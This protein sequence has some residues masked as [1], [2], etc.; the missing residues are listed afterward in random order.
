MPSVFQIRYRGYK[1]ILT[2][3]PSMR[4]KILAKFRDSMR[5]FKGA[6]DHGLYVVDYSKPYA[7][8]YLNDETVLLL[9]AL[10]VSKDILLGK[11]AEYLKFLQTAS[12]GSDGG[13][14]AFKFCTLTNHMDLAETLLIEGLEKVLPQVRTL[15]NQENHKLLNKKS[16]RRCRIMVPKSRLIFGVCDPYD[17]L[18]EGQC[19]VRITHDDDGVARTITGTEVLV[20][21]NPCLHPGDLQKFR[22]VNHPKLSDLV[23]CIVFPTKGRRPSADLMSGGDLDGDKFLVCWDPDLVPKIISEPALYPGAKETVTFRPITHQD[24]LE[25][26]A[27]Y[28]SVSLGRVKNLYLDWARLKGPMSPE[29]QQLNRLFSQCV[30]GNRIKVPA[31]LEDPPKKNQEIDDFILDVLHKASFS[32]IQERLTAQKD[33]DTFPFEVMEVL[34]SNE[35]GAISEFERVKIAHRWLL[36]NGGEFSDFLP[37]F[38]LGLLTDEEKAWTLSLL[39]ISAAGPSLLM[40]GLLQSEL[41]EPPELVNFQLHHPIFHWKPTFNSST[42][43]LET[44]LFSVSRSMELFHK[45]LII[46]R[47][48]ERLTV[49]IYI[50]QKLEKGQECQVG[51]SVRVFAFPR[52]QG[53]NSS[54]YRV[55]PTKVNYRLFCDDNVL[56]LYDGK[57]ANTF[58]FLSEGPQ[59]DS[60]YRQEKGGG[61]RRRQKQ[62]AFEDG[63]NYACRA[64]ISLDK[65]SKD[66]QT[67]VGR[68]NRSGILAAEVYVISNRDVESLRALDLWLQYVDTQEK[69]P[70]FEDEAK[71]FSIPTLG[72]IEWASEPAF[73]EDILQKEN[74]TALNNLENF[75]EI[76]HVMRLLLQHNERLRLRR[77]FDHVLEHVLPGKRNQRK[78]L[79]PFL[80]NILREAPFLIQAFLI[81]NSWEALFSDL[82]EDFADAAPQLLT[83]LVIESGTMHELVL[84]PFKLVLGKLKYLSLQHLSQIVECIALTVRSAELAMDIFLGALE[85]EGS[86]LLV[87]RRPAIETFMRGIFGIALDHIDEALAAKSA[88]KGLLNLTHKDSVS[89]SSIVEAQLRVDAPFARFSKDD[90]V[91]LTAANVPKNFPFGRPFSMDAIVQSAQLGTATFRCLHRPPSYLENCSWH[92]KNCGSFVTSRAMLDAVTEFYTNRECCPIF[93]ELAGLVRETSVFANRDTLDLVSVPRADLNASQNRAIEAAMRSLVCL[94]WGPPGTGKTRTIVA[95]IQEMLLAEPEKRILV[96]APTHNAVDNVLRKYLDEVGFDDKAPVPLRVTTDV[97]KVSEDL[98]SYTCDGMLGKDINEHPEARRKA[99]KRVKESQLIFSTCIGAGVGLLRSELFDTVVIDEASQQTEPASLVPLVKGATRAVLVGDHVQLRATVQQNALAQGFDVSLFERLYGMAERSGVRKVMLDTQ[100]RMH[101]DICSFSSTEFYDS[102]L[103]TAVDDNDRPLPPSKFPWPSAEPKSS[104]RKVFIPCLES[105]DLGRKSKSN[106]VQAI[107]CREVCK[108]LTTHVQTGE[109]LKGFSIAVLSPYV[110]QAELLRSMLPGIEV[111][112]VDSFQGKE[113]DIIVYPT[114]RCNTRRESGFLKDMRRLNVAITRAKTGM[115]LIGH[116]ETLFGNDE[117]KESGDVWRRLIGSCE[118]VG[119]SPEVSGQS[120]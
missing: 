84:E 113:A 36:K 74:L 37:F 12:S 42:D 79:F 107:L 104:G 89:G 81:S 102:K 77:L 80:V 46:L 94:L 66:V 101:R 14:S 57:R 60:S 50:P 16:E 10:G 6:V 85:P 52:S 59:N 91:Q 38:N 78:V 5:K 62:K 109:A 99:Q 67:H 55:V 73:V 63:T 41:V 2:Y 61:D 45:K 97:R 23:D 98:K 27:R 25:Y 95:M 112:S 72:N 69:L 13:H 83:A 48:D 33:P 106:K 21:R 32:W 86:R 88:W 22:A 39:P 7:Y 115:V 35:Y 29:C 31:I 70:L 118:I 76:E 82:E 24:R 93:M 9:H 64:S 11:Q 119:M 117:D 116:K 4:G 26:F 110:R 92:L 90:H 103:Q 87:G 47:V 30:D 114:V 58:I 20:T 40:N 105:E 15:V 28:S 3:E 65:I 100:Y 75:S 120:Q 49:A 54:R 8:G 18:R 71:E 17:V 96:A 51:A 43:R 1:G 34:L 68:I 53:S 56:Q 108:L 44:F 19:F 111:S